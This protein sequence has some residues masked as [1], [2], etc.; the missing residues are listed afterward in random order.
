MRSNRYDDVSP[1]PR[2]GGDKPRA[3]RYS[4]PSAQ[5][6]CSSTL[7]SKSPS[8]PRREYLDDESFMSVMKSD[9]AS[10]PMPVPARTYLGDTSFMT[11]LEDMRP[12]EGVP[13]RKY[14]EEEVLVAGA[15]E[16]ERDESVA[17]SAECYVEEEV[18]EIYDNTQLAERWE[19]VHHG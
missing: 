17:S 4:F 7:P 1:K 3:V 18:I 8:L 14:L 10:V 12:P 11:T 2:A 9:E 16:Q 13:E 5:C 6:A 19:D 15:D